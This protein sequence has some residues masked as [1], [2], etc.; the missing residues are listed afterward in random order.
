MR[1]RGPGRIFSGSRRLTDWRGDQHRITHVRRY[2]LSYLPGV[3]RGGA[4]AACTSSNRRSGSHA[5]VC[6]A[7]HCTQCRVC[8]RVMGRHR[9]GGGHR[10]SRRGSRS[11]LSRISAQLLSGCGTAGRHH[12]GRTRNDLRACVMR[13]LFTA[14]AIIGTSRGVKKRGSWCGWMDSSEVADHLTQQ[15][16]GWEE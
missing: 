5:S 15:Y 11:Q 8:G 9:L 13:A 10:T 3:W 14:I 1:R 16:A 7:C 2:A 6:R 12:Q 4:S